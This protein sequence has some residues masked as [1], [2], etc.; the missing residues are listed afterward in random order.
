MEVDLEAMDAPVNIKEQ[1]KKEEIQPKAKVE[2]KTKKDF[3]NCLRN[4]KVTIKFVPR[5][6]GL[7]QDPKH[8]LYGG[9]GINSKRKFVVP[10]LQSGAYVNVLTNAEKDFLENI[11]GLSENAMSIYRKV[12]NFWTNKGVILGKGDTIL[13]LSNPDEYIKYKILLANKDYICPDEDTLKKARKATYQY[14][15]TREGEEVENSIHSLDIMS[16]AYMLYGQLK[17]DLK[18]LALIVEVATG[19]LVS[20]TSPKTVFASVDA[21][22]K[23][24]PKKFIEAAKDPYLKTKLL[25]KEAV[26]TGHIR[27][28]GLYYYLTEGN[29]PLCNDTQEPTLQS[30]CEYL[31][32]PRYQEV[33]LKLEANIKG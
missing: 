7:V 11:M 1:P 31:N 28:S 13:D 14:V 24:N 29:T 17:S 23:D 3:I 22:I 21:L 10:Q 26:I 20:T 27:K 15:I 33:K 9:L 25:I 6:G 30:A 8:I 12:D 16:N 2:V 18:S 4:E 32:A 5:Q 19:K